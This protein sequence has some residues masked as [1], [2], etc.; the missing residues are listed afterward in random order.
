MEEKERNGEIDAEVVNV[1]KDEDVVKMLSDDTQIKRLILNCFCEFLSEIKSL[2]GE[3]NQLVDVFT[4]VSTD[5]LKAYFKELE[6]NVDKEETR[7]K[8]Q[9]KAIRSHKVKEKK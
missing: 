7:Q 1:M 5:K 8:V 3:V 6:T 4:M 9:K 2:R